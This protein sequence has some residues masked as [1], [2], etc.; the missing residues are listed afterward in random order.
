MRC[1]KQHRAEQ[2]HPWRGSGVVP[3]VSPT[4]TPPRLRSG[5]MHTAQP[6]ALGQT[7]ETGQRPTSRSA[8]DLNGTKGNNTRSQS[9]LQP[10]PV[11][12]AML[13]PTKWLPSATTA[14]AN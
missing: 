5:T 7:G 4:L 6:P 14:R 2:I 8:G 3:G 1:L 9:F 11:P 13:K 12:R 10:A